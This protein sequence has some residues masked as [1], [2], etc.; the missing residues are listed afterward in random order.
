LDP[1]SSSTECEMFR[2]ILDAKGRGN[3]KKVVTNTHGF[4]T[5]DKIL[6][7]VNSSVSTQGIEFFNIFPTGP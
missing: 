7:G 3:F 4:T 2:D 5:D 6:T 1:A